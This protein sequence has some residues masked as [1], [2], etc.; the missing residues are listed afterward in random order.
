[1]YVCMYVCVYICMYICIFAYLRQS[2]LWYIPLSCWTLWI[3][4][5]ISIFIL[6]LGT[7]FLAVVPLRPVTKFIVDTCYGVH[8]SQFQRL[9]H[10]LHYSV[11]VV[12]L[13]LTCI[14]TQLRNPSC[15]MVVRNRS[16][17]F[18][19]LGSLCWAW[20]VSLL[21]CCMLVSVFSSFPLVTFLF[22][23]TFLILWLCHFRLTLSSYSLAPFTVIKGRWKSNIFLS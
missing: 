14:F 13:S 9:A 23:I 1:M 15:F 8:I 4:L 16:W 20:E 19:V 6:V 17:M 22:Q 5:H 21:A 2:V 18:S 7:L 11:V 3:Q 10:H 12:P